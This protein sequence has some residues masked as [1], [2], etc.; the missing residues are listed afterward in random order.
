MS[1]FKAE[2][3]QIQFRLGLCPRTRWGSLQRSP[4]PSS[5][6]QGSLLLRDGEEEGKGE[7]GREG[8]EGGREEREGVPFLD[9]LTWQP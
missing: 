9:L 5:C 3:H 1:Y 8:K 4:R 2:M 6:I 7:R